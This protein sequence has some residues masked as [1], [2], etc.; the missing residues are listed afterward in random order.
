M[1]FWDDLGFATNYSV[2][3]DLEY[4]GD[5]SWD[6]PERRILK[7]GSDLLG[8]PQA[9]IRPAQAEPW[10]LVTGFTSLG[11]LYGTADPEVICVFEQFDRLV[12]VN[13]RDPA[14]Q[15]NIDD[16]YPVR[17]AA[18]VD[19]GL[20][21]VCDWN[22]ITAVATDGVRWHAPDLIY[23]L[24]VTRADGDRIYYRGTDPVGRK[25]RGSVD[26]RTGNVIP[27]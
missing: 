13:V 17:I 25:T 7:P 23:D 2:D 20:L 22:G 1:V 5:G 16:L 9:L 3:S 14:M 26:A 10:L 4:P 19:E 11:A 18:A 8:G 6:Y 15:A 12:F 24:H 27:T 21:L